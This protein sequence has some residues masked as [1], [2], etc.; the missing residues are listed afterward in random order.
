M[1]MSNC[2]NDVLKSDIMESFVLYDA[3]NSQNIFSS[4]QQI[5][6]PLV[7]S[8]RRV[9]PKIMN[10]VISDFGV[11]ENALKTIFESNTNNY[12]D[13][14]QQLKYVSNADIAEKL[15]LVLQQTAGFYKQ[16]NGSLGLNT[17]YF[18]AFIE[19]R[20]RLIVSD[21]G[22]NHELLIYNFR[23]G[24]YTHDLEML[25]LIIFNYLTYFSFGDELSNNQIENQIISFLHR[26]TK[27]VA[28]SIFDSE[29]FAFANK[30]LCFIDGQIVDHDS[31]HFVTLHTNVLYEEYE[32]A[33][34]F[35]KFLKEVFQNDQEIIGFV[36]EFM[37]Y[38]LVGEQ[39][40]NMFLVLVGEGANG[41]SCITT[42][43]SKMVGVQ[44]V[45]AVPFENLGAPFAMQ[46][47]IEKKMNLSTENLVEIPN[48]SKLKA[49]TSGDKVSVNRK[50]LKEITVRLDSKLVFVMNDAPIFKDSSYGLVRRLLVLPMT[51]RFSKEE[52]DPNLETKL[53]E[54]L[55]GILNWSLLGLRR[56]I[57]NN[58]RFSE[59]ILMEK[60]KNIILA[61]VDPLAAFIKDSI[62]LKSGNKIKSKELH[63]YFLNWAT[64]HNISVGSYYAANSFWRNFS[65]EFMI[66]FKQPLSKGK[67]GTS[68]VRDI[69]LKEINNNMTGAAIFED[70][71]TEE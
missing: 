2:T 66:Q 18:S 29:Y 60:T 63:D 24:Y 36:Q 5:N 15:K 23:Q 12:V 46:P 51:R 3:Q 6:I 32:N 1:V 56:L 19:N 39:R 68:V 25:R 64:E 38:L 62:V 52:Q 42:T 16:S 28:S 21:E 13:K 47:M 37:G 54:E 70:R 53:E 59:S 50:N 7:D 61:R 11:E 26:S 30:D 41:K 10:D 4:F 65:K 55:S 71:N 43:W 14:G 57:G 67:S 27:H 45:S 8:L 22:T 35:Q 40:A 58:Y 34:T 44:N 69:A 48:T 31:R 17:D 9:D 33:P 20:T 49:I